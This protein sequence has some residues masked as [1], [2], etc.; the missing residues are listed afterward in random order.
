MMLSI[1]RRN[2]FD[3][4]LLLAILGL[5]PLLVLQ[6]VALW[7]RVEFRFFPL[8]WLAFVFLLVRYGKPQWTT[9]RWRGR[10]AVL[11]TVAGVTAA[12]L[13]VWRGTPWLA[14]ASACL[15]ISAWGLLRLDSLLAA[16]WLGWTWL[17]WVT[18]PLPGGSSQ[19]I[20]G[21]LRQQSL[22][23]TSALL[24]LIGTPHLR[25]ESL[26]ELR[27][28]TLDVTT[29]QSGLTSLWALAAVA[30]FL[31][32]Y[33]R[34]PMVAG[35]LTLAT[36]PLWAW[37]GN[38]A[39]WTATVWLLDGPDIDLSTGW[40][41]WLVSL[42]LLGLLT[43]AIGLTA[44]GLAQLLARFKSGS[45]PREGR[46]L[47]LL[48]N[49]VVCWPEK[50]PRKLTTE[51]QIFGETPEAK[52]KK[53]KKWYEED[54]VPTPASDWTLIGF[55]W[56]TLAAALAAVLLLGGAYSVPRTVAGLKGRS[57]GALPRFDARAV[58]QAV[59][60]NALPASLSATTQQSFQIEQP[61][62]LGES[63]AMAL[64]WIYRGDSGESEF[65]VAFP[66][67]GVQPAWNAFRESGYRLAAPPTL[68]KLRVEGLSDAWPL[69]RVDL[70]DRN[71]VL[72]HL[73]YSYVD[74]QGN[75]VESQEAPLGVWERLVM[76]SGTAV[77]TANRVTYRIQLL[78]SP[79]APL[80]PVLERQLL[81][82]YAQ[83]LPHAVS[84]I[85]KL[86]ATSQ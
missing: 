86:P 62:P 36:V 80:T 8:A 78:V 27:S 20:D 73:W 38:V 12:G 40:L 15:L 13:A 4:S 58:A 84:V 14:Q 1:L 5:M 48:Y 71:G 51:E 82:F 59:E 43:T 85:P 55:K 41:F 37:L 35:A 29:L 28:K 75:P 67:R 49:T 56:T 3:A 64:R 47:H 50:P 83:A 69:V 17:L 23:A 24:D 54:A 18:V 57:G 65:S 70:E 31:L 32:A 44:D 45:M 66:F 81:A 42:L 30:V 26:L 39:Q 60:A 19:K 16:R 46:G 72:S 22:E 34:R 2:A 9:D 76:R 63:G 61:G 74:G 77:A 52:L 79:E 68:L 7:Q 33:Q 11:L 53:P 10:L 21:V 6:V 25:Y